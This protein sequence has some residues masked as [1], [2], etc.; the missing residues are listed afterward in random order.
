MGALNVL[1]TLWRIN[2]VYNFGYTHK[3]KHRLTKYKDILNTQKSTSDHSTRHNVCI[4]SLER[5]FLTKMR[6]DR[7]KQ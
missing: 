4:M 2:P 6:I 5:P 3:K 1:T 7:C